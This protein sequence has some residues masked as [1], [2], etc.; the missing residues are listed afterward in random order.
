MFVLSK[1]Y[2]LLLSPANLLFFVLLA[3][4]VLLFTRRRRTGRWLIVLVTSVYLLAGIL[5]AGTMLTAVLENRFPANPPL[6]DKV[7]GIVTL[8]GTVMQ[9]ISRD[10]G[11]PSLTDGSE[12]LIEFIHLARKYPDAKLVFSGGSGS[13][14]HP[15]L[16]ETVVVKAVLKELGFDDS[17]VMYESRSRNTYENALY[18][19]KLAKPKPG[20]TWVLIT[21]AMHMPRAMGCF[22]EVGWK[23]L[24]AYPVDYSTTGRGG[25]ELHFGPFGGLDRLETALHEWIGLTVYW[26]LG[27]TNVY[28]PG[29]RR[30]ADN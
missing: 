28:F 19:R 24:I 26:I 17:R 14:T 29:P 1:L 15:Q 22:R 27:R 9:V 10:R 8:G 25:F 4:T 23:N 7:A 13:L 2:W 20:E 5:P 12:R 11:Q 21:S 3:G 6:P 18:T 16:K 30:V